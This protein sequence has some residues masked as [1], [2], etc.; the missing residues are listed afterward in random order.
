M[1]FQKE[2]EM[3]T[4]LDAFDLP[5]PNQE[6]IIHL[7]RSM[8]SNEIEIVIIF[9]QRKA[10][11]QITAEFHQIFK[12]QLITTLLKVFQEIQKGRTTAKFML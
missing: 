3:A 6:N 7:S 10:Q 9:Q 12:E 2:K 8:I 1:F 5:K 11:D 4:F